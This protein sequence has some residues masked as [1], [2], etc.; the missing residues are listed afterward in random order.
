MTRN[1]A[2]L[3]REIAHEIRSLRQLGH[4]APAICTASAEI[5]DRCRTRLAAGKGCA[6][7]DPDA[8]IAWIAPY[9]AGLN[10]TEAERDRW[11]YLLMDAQVPEDH[12]HYDAIECD[13]IHRGLLTDRHG[14]LG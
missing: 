8:Y 11:V 7:F 2:A 10:G 5:I 14:Y 13:L 12:G 4:D 1:D 6:E 9:A 3:D